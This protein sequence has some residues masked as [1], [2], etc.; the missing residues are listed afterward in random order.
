MRGP[1]S[2]PRGGVVAAIAAA[3]WSASVAAQTPPRRPAPAVHDDDPAGEAVIRTSRPSRETTRVTLDRREIQ[4]IP[5]T[6]G[7]AFRAVQNLPGMARAPTL[8]G[9]L[10]VRGS[11]PQDTQ[12]FLDG[13]DIPQLYHFGGLTSVVSSDLLER[14]DFYPGN[15]SARFGRAQGGVIDAGMR[16]PTRTRWGGNVNLNLIDG[17]ALLEGPLA[18]NVT[19]VVSARRSWVDLVLGAVLSGNRNVAVLAAPVYYDY[20]AILTWRPTARDELRAFFFGSDD[21]LHLLNTR[22]GDSAPTGLAIAQH[23]DRLQLRWKHRFSETLQTELSVTPGYTNNG[24]EAGDL[25]F[26]TEAFTVSSRFNL[27]W[28]ISRHARLEAGLD[29]Q[30]GPVDVRYHG[31]SLVRVPGVPRSSA[32]SDFTTHLDIVRP[33]LWA[34]LEL[35]PASWLRLVPSLRLDYFGE[36]RSGTVSPRVTF[37]AEVARGWFVRGGVGSFTQP[38]QFQESLGVVDTRQ[39]GLVLGNPNL[40]AQ[41]VMHYDL[42]L[43]HAF[44]PAITASVEGF[45]KDFDE[46]VVRP[47]NAGFD[48][49]SLPYVNAGIGRAYGV[50]VLLRHRPT[51]RFFGWVSYTLMRSERQPLPTEPWRLFQFDQTHILTVVGSYRLGRGWE[52]GVRF[53]FVSG[54]PY[55]ARLGSTFNADTSS[56]APV[57][58]PVNGAR[59]PAFHQLDVRVDK[60]W[61]LGRGVTLDLYLDVQNIY[62]Q[63]NVEGTSY[64]FDSRMI[65]YVNGLPILPSLGIRTDF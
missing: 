7:D 26:D 63:A 4:R 3:W 28:Q 56:Y 34:E 36:I 25:R 54:N 23:F 65:G 10:I 31:P 52:V 43:E 19:L 60:I 44:S 13:V 38:P 48:I 58:G 32:L 15:F 62:N 29:V 41:R 8:T 57:S 47:G 20:Q 50:E 11:A 35:K 39:P 21:S 18:R 33:A 61:T 49:S 22:E 45:Y 51:S 2:R 53:R 14:L 5:G 6:S 64:S 12:V 17:S 37:R 30:S 46:Q 16:S 24:T 9:L 40:L 1:R 59:L 27:G 55:T 42:G